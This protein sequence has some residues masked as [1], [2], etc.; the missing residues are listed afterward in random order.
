MPV[1]IK[2]DRNNIFGKFLCD[3]SNV[4][5]KDQGMLSVLIK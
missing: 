1:I 5:K 4:R 3:F 2:E